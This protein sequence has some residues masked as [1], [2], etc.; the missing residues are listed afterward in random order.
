MFARAETCAIQ[1]I[2]TSSL[3]LESSN[4]MKNTIAL[5]FLTFTLLSKPV[6]AQ[7]ITESDLIACRDVYTARCL[8]LTNVY[9]GRLLAQSLG[10]PP[11]PIPP[12]YFDLAAVLDED[13]SRLSDERMADA[14]VREMVLP[15]LL[16]R[17]RDDLFLQVLHRFPTSNKG[18]AHEFELFANGSHRLGTIFRKL[19]G[20]GLPMREAFVRLQ[21]VYPEPATELLQ[22][23]DS[24]RADFEAMKGR[25]NFSDELNDEAGE[26]KNIRY[27]MVMQV[28]LLGT[29][30]EIQQIF[31]ANRE[32]IAALPAEMRINFLAAFGELDEAYELHISAPSHPL[33]NFGEALVSLI[34]TNGGVGN[35]LPKF[36]ALVDPTV[37]NTGV[38]NLSDIALIDGLDPKPIWDLMNSL[39]PLYSD[40]RGGELVR[41]MSH[42]DITMFDMFGIYVAPRI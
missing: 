1:R 39:A 9:S 7:P 26:L 5:F 14:T 41:S 40:R 37:L 15:N 34:R 27:L 20:R 24:V 10:F 29:P 38:S 3:H 19:G 28:I 21:A 35:D 6:F 25:L 33:I 13:W 42:I 4:L 18:V 11:Q 30:E 22:E 32:Q 31:N 23:M 16:I 2:N 8:L 36:M 12:T 17:G